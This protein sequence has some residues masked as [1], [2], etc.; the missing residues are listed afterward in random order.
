MIPNAQVG[1]EVQIHWD[2]QTGKR[3]AWVSWERRQ[4]PSVLAYINEIATLHIVK[5]RCL[6]RQRNCFA[7]GREYFSKNLTE[8]DPYLIFYLP[9]SPNM[10][11]YKVHRW[12]KVT[13]TYSHELN[14]Y[15]NIYILDRDN[16]IANNILI[17]FIKLTYTISWKVVFHKWFLILHWNKPSKTAGIKWRIS[18]CKCEDNGKLMIYCYRLSRIFA[19]KYKS[20]IFI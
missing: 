4:E 5:L 7:E 13:I 2:F 1:L 19:G 6:A 15:H 8:N 11:C 12:R 16:D 18:D 14:K 20:T 17:C 10:R 3:S 9:L